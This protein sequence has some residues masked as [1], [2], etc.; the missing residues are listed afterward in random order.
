[1]TAPAQQVDGVQS[2]RASLSSGNLNPTSFRAALEDVPPAQRDGW[3]D[4]VFGIDHI[5]ADGPHLPRG[6]SPYLPCPVDAILRTIDIARVSPL[7]V[8]VDV[9]S[10]V[11][12]A[13]LLV[14]LLTGA[15]AIGVE[16]QPELVAHSRNYAQQLNLSGISIVAGDA[17]E[18]TRHLVIGSVFFLYC[19]FSGSR[20][21]GVVD[22]IA[23]IAQTR[24]LRICSVGL[25]LPARP[26]LHP[27]TH[28]SPDIA[29][30]QSTF[31]CLKLQ[32][33]PP[34]FGELQM[35]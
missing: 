25:D 9:G 23:P 26:W 4:Q 24:P 5:A 14:H 18:L 6:C 8:F 15:S 21:Q 16:I 19:P 11:G 30:A 32:Q 34:A 12:R 22:S 33:A 7:D 35:V 2:V 3:L 20:L 17:T 27:L 28:E 29:V 13:A 31:P 1:V 10:G